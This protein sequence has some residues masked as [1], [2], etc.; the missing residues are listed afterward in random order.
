MALLE[1]DRFL[2][3]QSRPDR[4]VPLLM[5][6]VCANRVIGTDRRDYKP[7]Q[8]EVLSDARCSRENRNLN[9]DRNLN[10]DTAQA[11]VEHRV[12]T[13]D[14][15]RGTEMSPICAPTTTK[16]VPFWPC[17]E[18]AATASSSASVSWRISCSIASTPLGPIVPPAPIQQVP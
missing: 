6:R 8:A 9:T 1:L 15:N 13:E 3:K 10:R 14:V 4:H 5:A 16:P 7:L 12:M 17:C 11:V 2:A 18:P